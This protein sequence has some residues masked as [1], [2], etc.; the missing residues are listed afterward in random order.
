[1]FIDAFRFAL[2]QGHLR[3]VRHLHQKDSKKR[4]RR[5]DRAPQTRDDALVV[6]MEKNWLV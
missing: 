3:P 1:M 5:E 2:G 6:R 4:G